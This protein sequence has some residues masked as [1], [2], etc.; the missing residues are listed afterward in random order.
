MIEFVEARGDS[1]VLMGEETV[2]PVSATR[3]AGKT[4]RRRF[5]DVYRR[6]ED[7]RWFLTIRQATNVSVE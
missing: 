2:T 7:S 5:T 4:V 6:A 3:D 1:V